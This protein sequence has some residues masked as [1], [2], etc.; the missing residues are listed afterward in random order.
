MNNYVGLIKVT[1]DG[2]EHLK[3]SAQVFTKANEI[4]EGVGGKLVNVW[5]V[6]GEY[7]FVAFVQYPSEVAAFEAVTKM[8]ELGYFTTETLPA[9]EMERFLTFV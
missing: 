7:D 9:F 3:E 4:I 2:Y 1:Q 8:A 6:M 5:A